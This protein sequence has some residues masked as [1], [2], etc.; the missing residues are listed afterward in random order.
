VK[1]GL[2]A[3]LARPGGNVTG[4]ESLAPDLDVKR[5]EWLKHVIPTLSR[6]ALLYN[7]PIPAARC[8]WT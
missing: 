2:F 8:T 4:L 5:L 3:S 1:V 7:P 6:I